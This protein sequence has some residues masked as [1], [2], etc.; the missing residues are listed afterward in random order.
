M[1]KIDLL[2]EYAAS[3]AIAYADDSVA[4]YRALG[5][6]AI[7]L[8]QLGAIDE[9]Y[10]LLKDGNLKIVVRGT[11]GPNDWAWRNLSGVVPVPSKSLGAAVHPGFWAGAKTLIPPIRSLLDMLDY[12]HFAITGHSKGGAIAHLLGCALEHYS[13][14]VISFGAPRCFGRVRALRKHYRVAHELDPVPRTPPGILGFHHVGDDVVIRADGRVEYGMM[15]WVDAMARSGG[16]DLIKH[17]WG[18]RLASHFDYGAEM[19][20]LWRDN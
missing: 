3:C 7:A 13:P 10:A 15:A 9:G 2:L 11:D 1:T 6:K 5:C 16:I 18:D 4:A 20:Q 17:T 8:H 12:K 14:S 19:R